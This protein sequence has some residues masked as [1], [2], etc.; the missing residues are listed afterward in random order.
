MI[1]NMM[2]CF[3]DEVDVQYFGKK[4][5]SVLFNIDGTVDSLVMLGR[6]EQAPEKYKTIGEFAEAHP[7][8]AANIAAYMRE[9]GISPVEF[10]EKVDAIP[11]TKM[12][13]RCKK[14]LPI[15]SFPHSDL[16][17]DGT[18]AECCECRIK[19]FQEKKF[20]CTA[21]KTYKKDSTTFRGDPGIFI[22]CG[23]CPVREP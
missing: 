13:K 4:T 6:K 12:C 17:K 3:I 16:S 1:T 20:Y 23:N 15:G 2:Q 18:H 5:Y 21:Y 14:S 22:R 11:I 7:V 19:E 8:Q 9:H 10:P